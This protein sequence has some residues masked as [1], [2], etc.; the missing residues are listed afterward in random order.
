MTATFSHSHTLLIR[1]ILHYFCG[2]IIL[3]IVFHLLIRYICIYIYGHSRPLTIKIC[4]TSRC[5]ILCLL[6]LFSFSKGMLVEPLDAEST[7]KKTLRKTK[8]TESKEKLP[9]N[10]AT[11]YDFFKSLR[12]VAG[13]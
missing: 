4:K 3:N 1:Y 6:I 2:T 9:K 5:R 11:L 7:M 8:Q 10:Y 12:F 13:T